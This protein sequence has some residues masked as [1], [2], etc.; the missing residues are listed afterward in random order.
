MHGLE[1]PCYDD[2]MVSNYTHLQVGVNYNA[3]F[4]RYFDSLGELAGIYQVPYQACSRDAC[5][6]AIGLATYGFGFLFVDCI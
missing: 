3:D 1:A 2:G 4:V 6:Y 5:K